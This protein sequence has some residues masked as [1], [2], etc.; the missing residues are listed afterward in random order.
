MADLGENI[1][2]FL[3]GSTG[4]AAQFDDITL[5]HVVEQNRIPQDPPKPRIWFQRNAEVK[6]PD[7][8][9]TVSHGE[10][11]WDIE[12]ISEDVDG[13]LDIATEVKN[14]LNAHRGAF[15]ANSIQGAFVFDHDDNY[16]VKGLGG[17]TGTFVAALSVTIF[18]T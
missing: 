3:I 9:G 16:E 15:G 18:S 11:T 4:V 17:D 2:S 6:E 1:R 7:L 10:S 8:G 14:A 13:S 5:A 12:C